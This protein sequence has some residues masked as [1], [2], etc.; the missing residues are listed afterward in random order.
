MFR[1]L[2]VFIHIGLERGLV[3]VAQLI[4]S[5]GRGVT[6]HLPPSELQANSGHSFL[7]WWLRSLCGDYLRCGAWLA[8]WL[9]ASRAAG[10]SSFRCS[11]SSFPHLSSQPEECGENT[12]KCLF[13]KRIVLKIKP[14]RAAIPPHLAFPG[15]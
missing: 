13:F 7:R 14:S 12:V 5:S 1:S 6:T 2:S 10:S 11:P 9:W 4:P 15:N 3:T 8:G